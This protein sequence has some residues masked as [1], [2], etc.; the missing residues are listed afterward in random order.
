MNEVVVITRENQH[1]YYDRRKPPVARVAVGD[2]VVFETTDS[3]YSAVLPLAP[4]DPGP[5][6]DDAVQAPSAEHVRRVSR[7]H[8]VTLLGLNPAKD[9]GLHMPNAGS[10]EGPGDAL[11]GPVFIEGAQ[12]GDTLVVEVLSIEQD[13]PGFQLL[14][15]Y[16]GVVNRCSAHAR[17]CARKW[18]RTMRASVTGARLHVRRAGA[19]TVTVAARSAAGA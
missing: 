3:C 6:S 7:T 13:G 4:G 2:E 8:G 19:H 12:P 15:P 5:A 1:Q 11:T 14:G 18:Q 10:G 16:R 9:A 17:A